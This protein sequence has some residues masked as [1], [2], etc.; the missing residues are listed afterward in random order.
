[1]GLDPTLT[2]FCDRFKAAV[3]LVTFWDVSVTKRVNGSSAQA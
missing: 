3:L 2:C 1:M